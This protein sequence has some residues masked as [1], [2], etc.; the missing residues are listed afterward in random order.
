MSYEL[1]FYFSDPQQSLS[2]G[3]FTDYFAARP[4]YR[5]IEHEEGGI[6]AWYLNDETEVQFLFS[7]HKEIAD[8]LAGLTPVCFSI[9]YCAPE[10]F[11]LEA[12]LELQDF[13]RS[14][15]LS[16]CDPQTDG[17]E[18][19]NFDIDRFIECWG[20]GNSSAIQ[21]LKQQTFSTLP[22]QSGD[23]TEDNESE[24]LY[25]AERHTVELIWRWNYSIFKTVE[26]YQRNFQNLKELSVPRITAF[27]FPMEKKANP[28]AIWA[29]GS[30]ILLPTFVEYVLILLSPKA[31]PLNLL[32]DE[33]IDDAESILV[34]TSEL[35]E[36]LRWFGTEK[37]DDPLTPEHYLIDRNVMNPLKRII[38]RHP[39]QEPDIFPVSLAKLISQ[40]EWLAEAH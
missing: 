1:F 18:D 23:T 29:N 21:Q 40:D 20:A 34:E 10:V 6:Q 25:V 35:E 39:I 30:P 5:S 36:L 22:D 15:S 14:F 4:D 7:F 19:G 12:A 2:Q 11:A 3:D 32:E 8:E 31:E 27:C 13:I 38:S 17:M 24:E 16:V 33:F 28:C 9:D 37:T 26:Y